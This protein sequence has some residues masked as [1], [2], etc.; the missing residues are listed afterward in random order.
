MA[1]AQPKWTLV[2]TQEVFARSYSPGAAGSVVV[3]YYDTPMAKAH[4]GE[5]FEQR[6]APC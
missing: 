3:E 6:V 4:F 1:F 5:P 2:G